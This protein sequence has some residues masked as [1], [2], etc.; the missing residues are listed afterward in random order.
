MSAA[1]HLE[2]LAE[3]LSTRKA[4]GERTLKVWGHRRGLTL[5]DV[6]SLARQL[7]AQG[8]LVEGEGPGGLVWR[9]VER[10]TLDLPPLEI[11]TGEGSPTP[12]PASV[13]RA[14]EEEPQPSSRSAPLVTPRNPTSFE[15][16]KPEVLQEAEEEPALIAGAIEPCQRCAELTEAYEAWKE[17]GERLR[18]QL[19]QAR[20]QDSVA[21][22]QIREDLDAARRQLSYHE[23]DWTILRGYLSLSDKADRQAILDRVFAL[24]RE[25]SAEPEEEPP[26][27]APAPSPRAL[28]GGLTPEARRTV[29]DVLG[30]LAAHLRQ[31][32]TPS[33]KIGRGLDRLSSNARTVLDILPR[34]EEPSITRKEIKARSGLDNTNSVSTALRTLER[35][36]LA[37]SPSWGFGRAT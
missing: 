8:R 35:L 17:E 37:S 32:P 29:A 22:T 3:E 15:E 26:P 16:P 2:D 31:E 10:R 9:P 11:E 20:R 24:T 5:P 28:F 18:Q 21:W 23:G 25:V 6:R 34:G 4:A 1:R 27:Q 12:P 33:G 30:E 36:G 7:V 19:D 14:I 13:E